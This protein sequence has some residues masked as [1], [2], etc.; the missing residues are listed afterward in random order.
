MCETK[1]LDLGI[2]YKKVLGSLVSP[3]ISGFT[4]KYSLEI[5][6]YPFPDDRRTVK[7]K[8]EKQKLK[9]MR[10]NKQ[11]QPGQLA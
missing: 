5:P 11:Q 4:L 7:E 10:P 9:R 2:L 1:V 6:A 3:L 8:I